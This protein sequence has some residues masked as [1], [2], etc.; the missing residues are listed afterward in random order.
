VFPSTEPRFVVY[1]M[2][3]E[4]KG[5]RESFGYATG[6]WTAA[7]VVGGIIQRMAP[8]FGIAPLDETAPDIVRALNVNASAGATARTRPHATN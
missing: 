5:I 8:L 2:L 4:P 1:V 3:D 6:G 7:P